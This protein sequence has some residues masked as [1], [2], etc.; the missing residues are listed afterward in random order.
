EGTQHVAHGELYALDLLTPT[1]SGLAAMPAGR[2]RGAAGVIA[3]PGRIY[4]LGGESSTAAV[5]SC[6]AFDVATGTWIGAPE[7]PDLPAP[8]SHP[9]AMRRSD[10]S[11]IVAGGFAGPDASDPRADVWLLPPEGAPDRQWRTVASMPDP[12]GGCAYGAVNGRLVCAGGVGPAGP[13]ASVE[14]YDPFE[15]DNPP[16]TM[17][18]PMPVARAV[19][20][21]AAVGARLIVP[22]GAPT[23]A[24]APTDTVYVYAPLDTTR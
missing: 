21:G 5:A 2:E 7:L 18:E 20:Q 9:A 22:G 8:R 12:R 19:A 14:V 24:V 11:L 16:W 6:L 3:T 1:W 13:T 17:G 4:L 23:P 15:A 10:G